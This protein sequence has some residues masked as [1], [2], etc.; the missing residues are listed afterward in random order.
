MKMKPKLVDGKLVVEL[1]KTDILQLEKAADI[2]KLLTELG[3][4][5]GPALVDAINAILKAH[6]N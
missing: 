3:R 6:A 5:E 4:E 1:H 2:G